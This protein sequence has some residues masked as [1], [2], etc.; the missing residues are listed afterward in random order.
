MLN[1]SIIIFLATLS[2]AIAFGGSK[3]GFDK[4]YSQEFIKKFKE[5]EEKIR[6]SFYFSLREIG[7]KSF[8]L[9]K[10]KEEIDKKIEN[11]MN[12]YRNYQDN[13]KGLYNELLNNKK[14]FSRLFLIT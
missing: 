14:N 13:I 1:Q 2:L 4:L 5:Y 11:F 12:E 8:E 6:N 9:S 10:N 3:Y 7:L